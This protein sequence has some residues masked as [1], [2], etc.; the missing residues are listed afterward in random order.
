MRPPTTSTLQFF[1][2]S[3]S[4]VSGLTTSCADNTTTA[5]PLAMTEFLTLETS[6]WIWNVQYNFRDKDAS[7]VVVWRTASESAAIAASVSGESGAK[8]T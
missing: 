6:N 2:I 1:L 3:V 7:G 8:A 4:S 5:A